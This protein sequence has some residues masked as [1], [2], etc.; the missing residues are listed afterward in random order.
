MSYS[1]N[2]SERFPLD[3]GRAPK[4]VRNAYENLVVNVLQQV[5]DRANPPQIKRLGAYKDLWRLRVANNYR[6]VYR[7]DVRK[8]SVCM[9]MLDHR[10]KIYERL[11]ADEKG[12]PGLRIIRGA[13]ELIERELTP[14]E[15][16][17]AA[18]VVKIISPKPMANRPLPMSLDPALLSGW[19]VAEQHQK[20]LCSA[21]TEDELLALEG[22]VPCEV[23]EMVLNCLW[24]PNIEEV[25][26][27]PVRIAQEPLHL[28][29]A[30]EGKRSLASFLLALDEEQ[31]EFLTRF[32]GKKQP[33]GP[34]LLKGGPGSGK[35]T[36]A[37]YCIRELVNSLQ[38]LNLFTEDRPM[39]ILYT[40]YTNSLIRASNHLLDCLDLGASR[41]TVEVKTV[42]SLAAVNLPDD[43]VSLKPV[44]TQDFIHGALAACVENIP[45]Y[46]FASEDV[47]FLI[48]EIDWVLVGQGLESLGAYQKHDRAGRGRSLGHVQREHLWQLYEALQRLLRQHG[49]CLF[50]ER[51]R[52][53]ASNAAPVYDYVFIDE[54][55]DLK[56][57]AVRFLMALCHNRLNIFL[58]A[59]TN[60]SIWGN[61]FTWR[62]MA[63]DLYVQG[64]ARILNRNYRTT[65]E[66]WRAILQLAP[67]SEDTDAETLSVKAV[68]HGPRPTLAYYSALGQQAERLNTYL[69]DALR[70]E[71][72]TLG[73]AA[74]LCPTNREMDQVVGMLDKRFKARAMH[75]SEVDIGHPGVKVMTMHAAKGLEFPIVA[76]VGLEI[77]RM[78]M[79]VLPGKDPDEHLAQQKRLLFVA[80]S[81]AMRRM[82]LFANRD[83]PCPFITGLT[84]ECWDMEQ[85]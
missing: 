42:D 49:Y 54:A 11:G 75:S 25:V 58:T 81:R 74:V 70:A 20:A 77:G 14:A 13:Q 18:Q 53:A 46:S 48:E 62:K 73:S 4:K 39:R 19:G 36:V 47:G 3:L 38:Q 22:L 23:I 41:H 28:V 45:K 34:W 1:L 55:Q 82:I 7:V 57:V 43:W 51:L 66:V 21:H 6:L 26:Q 63:S 16:A 80:C 84:D 9:M 61:S 24:P 30:A 59:D 71:R 35:S 44:N 65:K 67:D 29:E 5:P 17:L 76:V 72:A 83:R 10:D 32:R 85:I 31:L 27:K 60:Q 37:L 78:P 2:F 15:R 64:R 8:R 12:E 68:F 79:R 33:K 52:V 40:T 69:W 50:S 56:A